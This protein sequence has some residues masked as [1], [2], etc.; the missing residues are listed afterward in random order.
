VFVLAAVHER[1][2]EFAKSA[3]E[4][5]RATQDLES[6]LG[7]RHPQVALSLEAEGNARAE[8]KD[9]ESIPLFQRARAIRD[10]ALG[11]GNALSATSIGNIGATH[12]RLGRPADALEYLEQALAIFERTIGA[13]SWHFAWAT[14]WL[15]EAHLRR[16]ELKTALA[17]ANRALAVATKLLDAQHTDLAYPLLTEGK[18]RLAGGAPSAAIPPLERSLALRDSAAVAPCRKAESAFALA[19]ALVA[20]GRD[21]SRALE[22]GRRAAELFRKQGKGYE[23]ELREVEKWLAEQSPNARRFP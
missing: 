14:Y 2:G 20:A 3:E 17:Y 15:G 9:P 6:T 16:G 4:A 18:A 23:G 22:L 5:R 19:R 1:L 13:D 7:P 8:M 10:S 11:P 12:V 21:R